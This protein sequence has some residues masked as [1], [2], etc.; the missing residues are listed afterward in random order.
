MSV[1]GIIMF[2]GMNN[3][4]L[5]RKILIILDFENGFLPT[6]LPQCTALCKVLVTSPARHSQPQRK[7]KEARSEVLFRKKLPLFCGPKGKRSVIL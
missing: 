1:K 4:R 3:T 5:V 2:L 7:V 6:Y